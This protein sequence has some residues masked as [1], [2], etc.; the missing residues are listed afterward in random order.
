MDKNRSPSDTS[1]LT[2]SVNVLTDVFARLFIHN[3]LDSLGSEPDPNRTR[4]ELER[5]LLSNAKALS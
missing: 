3:L 2:T 1:S 4:G 5:V